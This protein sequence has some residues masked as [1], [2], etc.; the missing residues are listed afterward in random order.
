MGE[1][2]TELV[3]IDLGALLHGMA[4][5]IMLKC[6]MNQVGCGVGPADRRPA[7][8]IDLR[9][10]RLAEVERAFPQAADVEHEAPFPLRVDHLERAAIPFE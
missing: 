3:G 9:S 5:E 2:E 4:A 1:V 8:R 6:R 7:G 10:H